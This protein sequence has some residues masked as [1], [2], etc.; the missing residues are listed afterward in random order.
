MNDQAIHLFDINTAAWVPHNRFPTVETKVLE[1]KATHANMSL[2]K[3]KLEAGGSIPKHIHPIET[4]TAIVVSGEV[5]FL[6][7][8]GEAEQVVL[9]KPD[10][11]VSIYPG[12]LHGIRNTSSA[13]VELLAIHSPGVV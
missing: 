5:E 7:G 8:E 3:V 11:G 6:Y 4:E 1:T 12:T 13:P 10:T 9:L 2:M